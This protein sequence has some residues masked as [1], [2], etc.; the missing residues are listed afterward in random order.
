VADCNSSGMRPNRSFDSS[1]G[2]KWTAGCNPSPLE[3]SS[4][5]RD[6]ALYPDS[7]SDKS[8]EQFG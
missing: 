4:K 8:L 7:R 5:G 6:R 1:M 3:S 2:R